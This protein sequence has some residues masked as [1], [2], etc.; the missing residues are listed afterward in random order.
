M[1]KKIAYV[2]LLIA[3]IALS[4]FC[5]QKGYAQES[6][7]TVSGKVIESGTNLPMQQVIL[8]VA[9]TGAMT[10]TNEQGEF[11]LK[12][13]DLQSE[14]I[15]NMPGYNMRRVFI[16]GRESLVIS[17]VNADFISNDNGYYH[18]LG[19][20]TLK[21]ATQS[22]GT[23][24]A[25]EITPSSSTSYDQALQGNT[26]GLQIIEHSGMPGHK[27]L[28][29]LRGFSSLYARSNPLLF[30]DGM[31]HDYGYADNSLMEGY[32]LN[33][34][35][36]VDIEDVADV[37]VVREGDAYLGSVGSNGVIYINTEQKSEASTVIKIAGYAG[38][39]LMPEKLSVMDASTYRDYLNKRLV[40]NGLSGDAINT[41][42][43]WLNGGE[44]SANYYKYNNSTDW[45]DELFKVGILQKY[46]IFLKGG[47]DI[48]TY[49]ISAG[50][51]N[52]EGIYDETA[53]SR[54][55]LR[56]NGKINITDR[57]SIT[58]NAKLSLAD[59]YLPNQGHSA[60]KNPLLS[61]LLKPPVM[62]PYARDEA[63][64]EALPYLDDVGMEK[65]SNPVSIVQGATGTNRNYHFLSSIN[66]IYKISDQFTISN[67]I[68]ISFNN[69][70]ENIFIPDKGLVD[71]GM[72][73]LTTPDGQLYGVADN[74][75]G[76]FI[77][78]FRSTQNHTTVSYVN[79]TD[80]GHQID[81][82]AGMRY[83]ANSYK[84]NFGIDL[85][86]PSDDFKSLGQGSTN[87]FLRTSTGDNRELTWISYFGN[88]RYNF[89]N[90]YYLN[91]NA[92]YEANSAV[93]Q[94]N[95]YNFF[96]SLSAA[97][98][99]S[100]EEFMASSGLIEDLKLRASWSQTGNMYSSV[101][102]YSKLYYREERMDRLGVPTREVIPNEDLE[103]ERK[104]TLNAGI[105][106]SFFRQATNIHV[107]YYMASVDNLIIEQKLPS[108]WGFTS[109]FDNGGVL[110]ISGLE[111][112][113]DQKFKVGDFSG[114]IAA[115]F[116][117]QATEVAQLN[118]ISGADN[119]IITP[120]PGAE[121][122]TSE[123]HALNAFYGYVTNGIYQSDDEAS[124]VTGPKGVPMKAGD[125][126]FWDSDGNN[127]INE[128]DKTIIG[129]PN[130]DFFGGLYASLRF[131]QIELS[132][133]FNYSVGN[134]VF[135]YVRY[136]AESMDGMGNQ[137]TT[138]LDRWSPERTNAAMPRAAFGDPSGNTV[139]SDRWIE[140]GSYFRMNRLTVTY[141]LPQSSW[142][143]G[144]AIYLTAS[145]LFTLTNYSGYD[146]EFMY[147]NN[148]FYMGIDY[149]QIPQ[150]RSLILGLK[151]DL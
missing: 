127:V 145:N 37:S 38:V 114:V 36:V 49:N 146:P 54:F 9:S 70:R 65:V 75:P 101:Y 139:F 16:L 99:V 137:F 150:S 64:G 123:G 93:N 106:L 19:T 97:W 84:H 58:P 140:D 113:I 151:L 103:L 149:G 96:P 30:I 17:L 91:A 20:T 117:Q 108:T 12:V 29:N 42:Y 46:Y 134:D 92:S 26:A 131:R 35:D 44:G 82:K 122:I 118:F 53:Y 68:G 4:G 87:S 63:T 34:M 48:A 8:S 119:R 86:T 2:A 130:P 109:Y 133:S 105:D 24:T 40:E 61:A 5:S 132:A 90:K 22:V 56:I 28:M 52:H 7:V 74:S 142:Y 115:N 67:L 138:V 126:K 57:F 31:I 129:D 98:R 13:P 51:L 41:A 25:G 120:V 27:T 112:S 45:Q 79:N 62:T 135:N 128:L 59:S 76:D 102:D 104:T 141:N 107:D 124:K 78:E 6:G 95:R 116:T 83:M 15:V 85:N 21:N 110:D 147:M 111:V 33:P 55:N 144:V 11:T 50:Y 60:F 69:A 94:Q 88:F 43:P 72:E 148:P 39:A 3:I 10:Q 136:K 80:N 77:N 73:I 121:Y 71:M 23:L 89:R 1:M 14:L 66:A 125:V 81:L 143:K 47:D 100:S 18:P 32:S